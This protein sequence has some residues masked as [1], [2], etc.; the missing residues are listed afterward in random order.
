MGLQPAPGWALLLHGGIDGEQYFDYHGLSRARESGAL[1]VLFRPGDGFY[2]P[3]LTAWGDISAAQF[4]S[5][6]RS[7]SEYRSGVE[8]GEQINTAFRLRIGAQAGERRSHNAVFNLCHQSATVDLDWH[9]GRSL[10]A[11]AGYEFRYGAFAESSPKDPGVGAFADAK[12]ADDSL[13]TDGRPEM[14]Y[15][16]RGHAQMSTLGLNLPL[17]SWLALDAQTREFHT[18]AA[19]GDHYNR[20]LTEFDLLARF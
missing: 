5:S 19:F 2:A 1:R 6:M 4:G 15:R 13:Q 11:Y 17:N 12:A 3:L 10:I 14:A 18:R 8:L 7:G 9:L 16:I 20:W